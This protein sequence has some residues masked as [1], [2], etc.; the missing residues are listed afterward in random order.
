MAKITEVTQAIANL[1][2]T[3]DLVLTKIEELKAAGAAS[4]AD[5]ENVKTSIEGV[6]SKL[7][8]AIS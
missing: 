1:Q 6:T 8:A 4:E 3:T 2:A 7:G 5:L